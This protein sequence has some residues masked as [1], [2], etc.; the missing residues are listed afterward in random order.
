MF[1]FTADESGTAVAI[2][3][4]YDSLLNHRI[5]RGVKTG[6]QGRRGRSSSQS[7]PHF[8][9]N[10]SNGRGRLAARK[11]NLDGIKT[12]CTGH[13]AVSDSITNSVY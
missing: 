11:E 3:D 5:P 8:V 2:C 13:F 6:A 7:D 4:M 10:A 9:G 1:N 12:N